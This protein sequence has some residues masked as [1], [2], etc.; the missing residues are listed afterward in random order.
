MTIC[1]LNFSNHLIQNIMNRIFGILC[2]SMVAMFFM[3]SCDT[4]QIGKSDEEGGT[5][6]NLTDTYD[7]IRK[8][9]RLILAYDPASESFVGTVENTTNGSLKQVRVEV[10]LSNGVELG[11]TT[12]VDLG[13][14]ETIDINLSA[15]N[16]NFDSWS[17]HAEVG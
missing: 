9:A 1:L 4:L 16:Q 10:H 6:L 2:M 13:P 7:E 17:P 11:P 12:P 5:Q 3:S 14:G 15:T 8:G